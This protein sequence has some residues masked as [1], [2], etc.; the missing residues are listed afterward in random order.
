MASNYPGSFDTLSNPTATSKMNQPG[1]EHDLLHSK[2][3][4]A[5]EAV[6]ATLGTSPQGS[7][8]TVAE[9]LGTLQRTSEKGQPGGYAALSASGEVLDGTGHPVAATSS[10][11]RVQDETDAP[12][13]PRSVL[14]FIGTGVEVTDD[15]SEDRVIVSVTGGDPGGPSGSYLPMPAPSN[16]YTSLADADAAGAKPGDFVWIIP[17]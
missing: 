7:S 11:V 14:T 4:D 3:N 10:Q 16:T 15:P 8:A 13:P 6:Q 17:A 2:V 5:V 1:V 9:R 12:F